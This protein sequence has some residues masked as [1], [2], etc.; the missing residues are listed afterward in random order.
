MRIHSMFY[1][2]ILNC[3]EEG[4]KKESEPYPTAFHKNRPSTL[5][6]GAQAMNFTKS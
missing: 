6:L 4:E 3:Q 5:A 2:K 1:A